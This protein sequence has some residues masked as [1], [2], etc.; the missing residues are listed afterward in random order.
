MTMRKVIYDDMRKARR[1]VEEGNAARELAQL[2][3]QETNATRDSF[4]KLVQSSPDKFADN[5][6]S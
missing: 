6:A 2:T 4:G 5:E 3:T 1:T